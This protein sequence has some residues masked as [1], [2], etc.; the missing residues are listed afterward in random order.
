MSNRVRSLCFELRKLELLYP[1]V[2]GKQLNST[3]DA[4][5]LCVLDGI[6]T[7]EGLDIKTPAFSLCILYYSR[8]HIYM[9]DHCVLMPVNASSE[10]RGS[11]IK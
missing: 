2:F 7:S 10:I 1:L 5:F 4:C 3:S 9:Y 8:M 11:F 6:L